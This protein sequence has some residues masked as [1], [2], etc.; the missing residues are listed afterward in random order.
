MGDY[1]RVNRAFHGAWL[2]GAQRRGRVMPYPDN[3][4]GT[5]Y[6]TERTVPREE[7]R[8]ARAKLDEAW[9]ALSE[10]RAMLDDEHKQFKAWDSDLDGHDLEAV[11]WKAVERIRYRAEDA[12]VMWEQPL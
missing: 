7:L 8:A 9:R 6:D 1:R 3:F 12:A 2:C 4:A 10:L 5:P 11:N